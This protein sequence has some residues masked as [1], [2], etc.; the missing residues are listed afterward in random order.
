M[1]WNHGS[2]SQIQ[3]YLL[4]ARKW[5]FAKVLGLDGGG[6]ANM[7]LGTQVHANIE[8]HLRGTGEL[9]HRLLA[10][11]TFVPAIKAAG[12]RIYIEHAFST[13]DLVKDTEGFID[14]IVVNTTTKTIEVWDHKTTKDWKYMKTEE[15]LRDDPQCLLY[16]WVAYSMFHEEFPDYSYRF[17]HHVIL[18]SKVAVEETISF[19]VTVEAILAGRDKLNTWLRSMEEDSK[20]L[21]YKLVEPTFSACWAYGPCPFKDYCKGNKPVPR[22]SELPKIATT[23][24]PNPAVTLPPLIAEEIK[25]KLTSATVYVNAIPLGERFATFA[26]WAEP[27]YAE[28]RAEVKEDPLATKYLQGIYAVVKELLKRKLPEH[29]VIRRG[30]PIAEHFVTQLPSTVRVVQ[31]L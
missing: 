21:D 5:W 11:N 9:D 31:G 30:D 4:C 15:I 28:Y 10:L 18:T 26:E 13:K 22:L 17:G 1:T 24:E 27:V 20:L 3:N 29:L 19:P 12:H 2:A 6:T 7:A 25:T 23:D 8:D 14:L 16:T